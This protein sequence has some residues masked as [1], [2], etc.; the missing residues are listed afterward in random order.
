MPND[1][2]VLHQFTAEASDF[3]NNPARLDRLLLDV[4]ET[5]GSIEIP[6]PQIDVRMK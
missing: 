5:P 2:D 6:Y 3:I 4:V 1:N